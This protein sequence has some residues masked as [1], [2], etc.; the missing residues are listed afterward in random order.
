MFDFT[1]VDVLQAESL[2]GREEIFPMQ[3][4]AQGPAAGRSFRQV[5]PSGN[6]QGNAE[7]PA[8]VILGERAA[9]SGSGPAAPLFIP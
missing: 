7:K 2:P 4:Q 5:F 3:E 8:A 6:S 1:V 9:E